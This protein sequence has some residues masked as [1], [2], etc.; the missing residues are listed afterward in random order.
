[1]EGCNLYLD[2]QPG[3]FWAT[4][5]KADTRAVCISLPPCKKWPC[6]GAGSGDYRAS[7]AART[8][9]ALQH[10]AHPGVYAA[11]AVEPAQPLGNSWLSRTE[12]SLANTQR[13]PLRQRSG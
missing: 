12:L 2:C 11:V 7:A 10:G 1:M 6:R 3:T 9:V 8:V 5:V 13:W 4:Y